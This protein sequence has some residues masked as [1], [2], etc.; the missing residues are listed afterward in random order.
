MNETLRK[1]GLLGI[2]VLSITEEKIRQTVNELVER[3]EMNREE[4][5]SLVNELLAEKNRQMRELG[6]K[7]SKDVQNAISRSNIAS[8]DDVARLEDKITELEKAVK[9]L[10]EK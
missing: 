7:I 4:G 2:G 1:M 3:G 6:D 5:K 10:I 9:E 8:K